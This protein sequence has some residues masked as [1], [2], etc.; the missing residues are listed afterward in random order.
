MESL[1]FERFAAVDV[2]LEVAL[3]VHVF[4]GPLI[5]SK[6]VKI[7]KFKLNLIQLVAGSLKIPFVTTKSPWKARNFK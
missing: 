1:V 7:R 5:D 6:P 2:R 4:L 3:E